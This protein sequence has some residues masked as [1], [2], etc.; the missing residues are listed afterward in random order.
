[1]TVLPPELTACAAVAAAVATAAAEARLRWER[2]R[3]AQHRAR[4]P[5]ADER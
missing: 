2:R 3:L 5:E 1:M 4:E